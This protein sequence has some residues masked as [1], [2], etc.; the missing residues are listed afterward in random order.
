MKIY[1]IRADWVYGVT[2]NEYNKFFFFKLK[3]IKDVT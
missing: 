2:F 1:Y 3:R